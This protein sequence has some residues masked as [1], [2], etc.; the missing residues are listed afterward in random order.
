MNIS[1]HG[2]T[3]LPLNLIGKKLDIIL[4]YVILHTLYTVHTFNK[5]VFTLADD[6]KRKNAFFISMGLII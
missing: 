4:D 1:Y 5:G 6:G 3:T 2:L